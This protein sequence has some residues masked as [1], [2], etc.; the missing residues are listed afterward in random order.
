MNRA[1]FM[2]LLALCTAVSAQPAP[3]PDK[4][5]ETVIVTGEKP[6]EEKAHDYI[7]TYTAPSFFLGK[8]TRWTS[9]RHPICP[10]MVGFT[11]AFSA[12]V[13]ARIRQVA[14]MVGAPV[15]PKE[16]CAANV[17]IIVT[18]TPQALLDDIRAHHEDMLGYF[19]SPPK[20]D[21]GQGGSSDPGLV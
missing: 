21:F 20:R 3:T 13:T 15:N 10:Q 6:P 8:I 7:Q 12:F 11:P 16:S 9:K 1:A 18:T 2:V 19:Q 17:L 5:V 14:K 4:K